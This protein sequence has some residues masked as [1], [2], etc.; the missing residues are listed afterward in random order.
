MTVTSQCRRGTEGGTD[1]QTVGH[2]GSAYVCTRIRR[3]LLNSVIDNLP[4]C[5]VLL[6]DRTT[7]ALL[8]QCCVCLS[9]VCDVMYCG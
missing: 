1:G 6:A 5:L 9:S 7:V 3:Q 2:A 4:T 8:V